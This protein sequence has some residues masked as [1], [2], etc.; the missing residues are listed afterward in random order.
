MQMWS[1]A[2]QSANPAQD[3]EK[4][5]YFKIQNNS[6]ASSAYSSQDVK[7]RKTR[8]EKNEE[9]AEEAARQRGCIRR[10]RILE[11]PLAGQILSR[12]LG[13]CGRLDAAQIFSQGLVPQG[14]YVPSQSILYPYLDNFG[15]FNI[16]FWNVLDVLRH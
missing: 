16:L 5:K 13:Q 1:C 8:D 11:A 12:E 14:R 4:K 6:P 9:R 15:S 2:V 10:S 7:R 3:K